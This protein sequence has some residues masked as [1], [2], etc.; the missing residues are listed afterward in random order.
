LNS[1]GRLYFIENLTLRA[2][3]FSIWPR[4]VFRAL[5]R[6]KGPGLCYVIDGSWP[7]M[8]LARISAAAVGVTVQKLVFRLVDV[9]D[10]NGLLVRLRIDY[11]DVYQVQRDAIEEPVFQR[12]LKSDLVSDRLPF[13]LVKSLG[14]GSRFDR[15]NLWR[16]MFLIQVCVWKAKQESR[17]DSGAVMFMGRRPWSNVLKRYASDNGL[18]VITVSPPLDAITLLRRNLPPWALGLVRELRYRRSRGSL[19]SIGGRAAAA[20]FPAGSNHH[21]EN[22]PNTPETP[23]W[24]SGPKV[25]VDYQGQLNLSE[26]HLHSDV[27]FWQQSS[28]E[29]GELLVTFA[30]TTDPLDQEKWDQLVGYGIQPAVLHPHATTVPGVPVFK[31]RR[32]LTPVRRKGPALGERGADA[33]WLQ[34]RVQEYGETRSYWAQL[35]DAH[36]GKVYVTY[37]KQDP[38]HCAIAD[39]LRDVGGVLAVYQ[40]SYEAHPTPTTTVCAD[41]AFSFSNASVQKE[42]ASRSAI[43][44]HVATGYLGDHRFALLRARSGAVRESL[45]KHGAR[46]ILAYFDENSAADERLHTGHSFMRENYDFLLE[47]VLDEPWLGLVLKPKNPENLRSRL[48]P[49]A[50]LLQKAE[51]TGRC[52]VYEGGLMQGSHSPAEAAAEVDLAIHG[53]LCG[54]TAGVESVLSGTPTLLLDREGWAV[55]PLWRLAQDRVVFTNWAD[56]WKSCVEHWASPGG[57]PSFADWSSLLDELDPF[58]DGRASER[59]GGYL[60]WLIQGFQAGLDRDTVMADAAERYCKQWG[61]D[62]VTQIITIGSPK[63]DFELTRDTTE[64]QDLSKIPMGS[65]T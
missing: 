16:I 26:A 54:G 2:W 10:E 60:H 4:F 28:L 41:V 15:H 25:V 33:A 23:V 50:Q 65:R 51:A 62:K 20:T 44:Y 39:A 35:F 61:A 18:E 29:A 52:Y 14:T 38:A 11:A 5:K 9:H 22:F 48:G 57:I 30:Y 24:K 36:N 31:A 3:L 8:Y 34:H 13:F 42:K 64:L 45:E 19:L 43:G 53:H 40:R 46:H 47:K 49:V 37:H 32:R 17:L 7:A 55:S 6:G 1:S 12:L 27:A 58:R 59:M 21:A 56:L 63:R